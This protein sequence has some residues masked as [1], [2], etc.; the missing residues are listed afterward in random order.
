[1]Q[2]SFGEWWQL[3]HV[4]LN[5]SILLHL[6]LKDIV[7][8]S[9][10]FLIIRVPS[11]SEP[12]IMYTSHPTMWDSAIALIWLFISPLIF[13]HWHSIQHEVM[14]NENY[15]YTWI[16]YHCKLFLSRN[17]LTLFPVI[18]FY[19]IAYKSCSGQDQ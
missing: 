17:T 11:I 10:I 8:F 13:A 16:T 1:M 9:I 14:V 4:V 2:I 12:V 7:D 5:A 3:V 18:L 19:L 15:R 6:E